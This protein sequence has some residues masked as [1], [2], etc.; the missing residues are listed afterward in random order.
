MSN[1][2][3]ISH[4]SLKSATKN[5]TCVMMKSEHIFLI[6]LFQMLLVVVLIRVGHIVNNFKILLEKGSCLKHVK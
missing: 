4:A 2:G 3:T 6:W 5:Q 1:S